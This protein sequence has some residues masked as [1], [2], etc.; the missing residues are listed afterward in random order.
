VEP[1]IEDDDIIFPTQ[2][3]KKEYDKVLNLINRYK[4]RR[5]PR[6]KRALDRMRDRLPSD[7]DYGYDNKYPKGKKGFNKEIKSL[8]KDFRAK[9]KEFEKNFPGVKYS[10]YLEQ[11][12]AAQKET[13]DFDEQMLLDSQMQDDFEFQQEYERQKQAALKETRDF[14]AQNPRYEFED[15]GLTPAQERRREYEIQKQAAEADTKDFYEAQKR[16]QDIQ[17]QFEFEQEYER[18]KQAA[19]QDANEFYTKNKRYEFEDTDLTPEQYRQREYE[20]QKQ[21]AEA[22]TKKFEAENP[23]RE[24]FEDVDLTPEQYRQMEYENQ[25][26]FAQQDIDAFE[27]ENP[28]DSVD[29]D[30][31]GMGRSGMNKMYPEGFYNDG[32]ANPREQLSI[33]MENAGTPMT[34]RQLRRMSDMDIVNKL[35]ELSK[36]EDIVAMN[37]TF[38]PEATTSAIQADASM[39]DPADIGKNTAGQTGSAVTGQG[40]MQQKQNVAT[41]PQPQATPSVAAQAQNKSQAQAWD[42]LFSKSQSWDAATLQKYAEDNDLKYTDI[43]K[44]AKARGI[45]I[46]AGTF[47]K[48]SQDRKANWGNKTASFFSKPAVTQPATQSKPGTTPKSKYST[49]D[50][51]Y[52]EEFDKIK[53]DDPYA[54]EGITKVDL[55]DKTTD[56]ESVDPYAKYRRD[57]WEDINTIENRRNPL[58]YT[59]VINKMIQGSKPAD[60]VKR[61]FYDPEEQEYVDRSEAQRQ[62]NI[63]RANAARLTSRGS[64]R[65]LGQ[66]QAYESQI[67]SQYLSEAERINEAEARRADAIASG[68]VAARNAAEQFNLNLANQYDMY[69]DQARAAKQKYLDVA[70]SDVSKLAQLEEQKRYMM[71]RDRKKNKMQMASVG[72]LGTPNFSFD[73]NDPFDV[74]Y[75]KKKGSF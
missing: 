35:G 46:P 36:D 6:A 16:E 34:R 31:Y 43:S 63:A 56:E 59:S 38:F 44:E 51:D 4:L 74:R 48:G 14:E 22:D 67:G 69:D 58:K 68:N 39:P 30:E 49:I 72:L 42:K 53:L 25:K 23:S 50:I 10:E 20:I 65:S 71:D 75:K 11:K 26:R 21:M 29:Y 19:M 55:T 54:N 15:V 8:V 33:I 5:D 57:A 32:S 1:G 40:S 2:N 64:A 73:P 24:P 61:R 12:R 62:A 47:G 18:Q 13:S 52:P 27:A 60:L 66:R 37:P 45:D 9:E 3:N 70:A 17:D 28:N 7:A 41:S